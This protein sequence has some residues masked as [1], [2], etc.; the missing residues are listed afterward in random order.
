MMGFSTLQRYPEL[1]LQNQ[2][3]FCIKKG[4]KWSPLQRIQ[5]PYSS[6]TDLSFFFG[7]LSVAVY[8]S[9]WAQL[10]Y[11]YNIV[12]NVMKPKK[13]I[14]R[15]KKTLKI[16]YALLVYIP[17]NSNQ[18]YPTKNYLLFNPWWR[19]WENINSID[20]SGY[21]IHKY[22]FNIHLFRKSWPRE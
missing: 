19:G 17:L 10:I 7:F 3:Q 16:F 5:S 6:H 9:I 2:M 20:D 11:F 8:I 13:P 21:E 1:D 15:E 4:G 12:S 18:S 14:H 22:K